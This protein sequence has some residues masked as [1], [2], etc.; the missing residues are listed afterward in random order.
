VELPAGSELIGLDPGLPSEGALTSKAVLEGERKL[1]RQMRNQGYPFA[2]AGEREVVVDHRDHTIDVTFRL[3]PGPVARLGEV[4]VQGLQRAREKAVLKRMTWEEGDLFDARLIEAYRKELLATGL[5]LTVKVEGAE[6]LDG[7]GTL[8]V[9]VEVRERKRRTLR[10]G[11][12]Y[13]TD[14]GFGVSLD[15]DYRNFLRREVLLQTTAKWSP[16]ELAFDVN[17][18]RE[19]F[20]H[21]QQRIVLMGR[22]AE[23]SPDAYLSLN[24]ELAVLLSRRVTERLRVTGGVGLRISEV[25]Q[26]AR[27]DNYTLLLSPWNVDYNFSDDLLDP[28]KGGRAILEFAPFTD[29]RPGNLTFTR[30]FLEYRQY[31]QIKPIPGFLLAGRV[32]LGSIGGASR[33]DIPADERFYAGGG[34]S[35]RG[36][37]YQSVGEVVDGTPLGGKGLFETSLEARARFGERFGT[38]LFLDGGMVYEA[39]NP[40]EEPPLQWGAGVG[41]RLFTGLGPVRLDVAVPVNP[42]DGFDDDYQFYISLGQAF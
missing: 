12:E 14:I 33:G 10:L 39:S 27:Q 32:A 9:N 3:V 36:Y 4:E 26:G 5:F 41:L 17:L 7:E 23:D 1:V 38:V 31:L 6:A 20:L 11:L 29:L 13:V 37:A 2:A 28:V 21:P 8:P 18:T 22:V 25:E 15:W 30:S 42:R 24:G 35:I 34:G 16:I 19:R 40:S